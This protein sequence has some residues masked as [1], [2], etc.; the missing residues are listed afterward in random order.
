MKKLLASAML[1]GV[2]AVGGFAAPAAAAK[3][4][5]ESDSTTVSVTK[6]GDWPY[7]G[8]TTTRIGD[9]PY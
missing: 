1:A 7:S 3:K 8:S 6:I 4:A 9:W 5:P 2:L